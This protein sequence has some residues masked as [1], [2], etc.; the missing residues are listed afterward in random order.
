[1]ESQIIFEIF[2]AVAVVLLQLY[3]FYTSYEKINNLAAI[4]PKDKL[5][6]SFLQT[7]D[8]TNGSIQLI[9][10]DSKL[11]SKEFSDVVGSINKYLSQNQGATDYSIIK[12]IVERSI[13]TK[14]NSVGAN[15]TLP[16]YIGLMGTFVGIIAGLLKIAFGGGVTE[17]NI[18]S[19]L[20]GVVIAMVA[21]LFGLLLTVLNN[22][23]NF[24]K[25]K[26]I[27]DERKNNFF[28]FL[29]I[30]LLPHLGNSLFDALDRLKYNINDF[31][32]K[33]ETNIQLFDTKF[34]V[35]ITSLRDSVQSIS[36]NIGTIVENTKS[37][38]EFLIRLDQIGYEK[39]ASA[40][41]KVFK[42]I[43]K[44]S[45]S[46]LQF[47]EKQSELTASV[48]HAA[49]FINTIENILNRIKTFEDSINR[50]GE[51]I[52]SKQYLSGQVIE[53]VDKNLSQLDK[54]FELLKRHEILSSEAIEEFFKNQYRK[55]Q[56]LTDNIKREV[57]SALDLK[58]EN[59]P[60]QKLL[61]LETLDKNMEEIKGKINFN[62]EFKKISEDLSSTKSELREIKDKLNN[63]IEDN[64]N[65]AAQIQYREERP[66]QQEREK[67]KQQ[68]TKQKRTL[69]DR[70]TNLFKWNRGGKA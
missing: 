39:M 28:D 47:V 59:N 42:L 63:A 38:K 24:R 64:R 25:A 50:L 2:V 41:A 22:S 56:E 37:Q 31:N 32:K 8:T 27:C 35:N 26:S 67:E 33:F 48:E 53:R 23:M 3:F 51:N 65:R 55:I 1:M 4:L 36:S 49:Q 44:V 52:N 46:M 10:N 57:E 61:L 12:S 6:K 14:E 17:Q 43:D 20:G 30:E 66:R 68:P 70:F 11:F 40:N 15:V 60:L 5:D 54:N 34:S 13:E 9:R 45:P 18:N 69:L 16:L 29:Q 21:S 58:I 62:G 7:T 19:F